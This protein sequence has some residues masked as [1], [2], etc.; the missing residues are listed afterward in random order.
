MHYWKLETVFYFLI[1]RKPQTHWLACWSWMFTPV[2]K[3]SSETPESS[4][5]C[6][7]TSRPPKN[8]LTFWRKFDFLLA[9]LIIGGFNIH[10]F[11]PSNP[12]G[13]EFQTLIILLRQAVR[14]LTHECGHILVLVMLCEFNINIEI[15]ACL[16]FVTHCTAKGAYILTML[17]TWDESSNADWFSDSF[18][19][20]PLA[21]LLPDSKELTPYFI[22]NSTCS[23]PLELVA[24]LKP[25]CKKPE[26]EPWL[27][28]STQTLT[29]ICQ[30]AK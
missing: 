1:N 8:S 9:A 20:N 22:L 28:G 11:C 30:R 26:Q 14:A 16:F 18:C 27:S 24:S 17:C 19:F 29:Q 4:V 13:K 3:C 5:L 25:V 2:L 7:V 12:L 6:G 15:D 23:N 21:L 10:I